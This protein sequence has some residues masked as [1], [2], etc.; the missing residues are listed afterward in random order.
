MT[1][2]DGFGDERDGIRA[3]VHNLGGGLRERSVHVKVVAGDDEKVVPQLLGPV[4]L[5]VHL[6]VQ[7][8]HDLNHGKGLLGAFFPVFDGLELL[9]HVQHVAA[10]LGHLKLFDF[11]IVIEFDGVLACFHRIMC[12]NLQR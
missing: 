2:A 9:Y 5:L 7:A 10:V 11:C 4:F 1:G 12:F 3:A 6:G 8:F